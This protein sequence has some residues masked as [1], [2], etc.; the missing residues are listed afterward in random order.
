MT[1]L[2]KRIELGKTGCGGI[3]FDSST[4]EVEGRD[5]EFED[6]GLEQGCLKIFGLGELMVCKKQ[7]GFG[8]LWG[9]I[10]HIVENVRLW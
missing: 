3:H 2:V 9:V 8:W 1:C 10:T 7:L 4:W 6:S 5:L